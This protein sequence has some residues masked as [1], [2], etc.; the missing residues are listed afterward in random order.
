MGKKSLWPEDLQAP[1]RT[2][3]AD[4]LRTQI[5]EL[6][7]LTKSK[8]TGRID[9]GTI[10]DKVSLDFMV[11]A[12]AIGYEIRLFKVLHRI[13]PPFEASFVIPDKRPIQ[14]NNKEE[15][16]TQLAHILGMERTRSLLSEL[17]DLVSKREKNDKIKKG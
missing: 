9:I 17:L 14:V 15:F 6:E 10:G 13:H 2:G 12:P 8:L 4:V 11:L 7:N 16:E 5:D 1:K 3:P